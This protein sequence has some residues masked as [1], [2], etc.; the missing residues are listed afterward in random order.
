MAPRDQAR[1]STTKTLESSLRAILGQGVINRLYS[2]IR[3]F[4]YGDIRARNN[5][6]F[7]TMSAHQRL[8]P[9]KP[10]VMSRVSM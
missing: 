10:R 9:L 2:A 7:S 3:V 1:D 5:P 8:Q 4:V 6:P